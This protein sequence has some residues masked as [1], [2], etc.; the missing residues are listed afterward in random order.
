MKET[1]KTNESEFNFFFVF[2]SPCF[3]VFGYFFI[4]LFLCFWFGSNKRDE[5]GEHGLVPL[6][7]E[8]GDALALPLARPQRPPVGGQRK[9][10]MHVQRKAGPHGQRQE[11]VRLARRKRKKKS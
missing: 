7:L 2:F 3:F 9:A 11:A 10:G 4:F 5:A 1:T 6:R 8:R